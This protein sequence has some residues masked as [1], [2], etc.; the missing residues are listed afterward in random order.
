[1]SGRLAVAGI[2]VAVADV[3]V[4]NASCYHTAAGSCLTQAVATIH[5]T[6]LSSRHQKPEENDSPEGQGAGS[7]ADSRLSHSG[8]TVSCEVCAY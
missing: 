3:C 2:A 1:M 4:D 7:A 8:P 5:C 6:V